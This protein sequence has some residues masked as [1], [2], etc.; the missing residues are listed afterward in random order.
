MI[1]DL[2]TSFVSSLDDFT[3]AHYFSFEPIYKHYQATHTYT[4]T[5]VR[6]Y[7]SSAYI[8]GTMVN[9]RTN[10]VLHNNHKNEKVN[11]I[12]YAL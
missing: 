8:L 6:H 4:H 2:I 10:I 5:R 9:V 3:H 7:F 11:N 12:R 1:T